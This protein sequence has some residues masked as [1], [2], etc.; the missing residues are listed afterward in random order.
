[1]LKDLIIK[2][3]SVRGYDPSVKVSRGELLEMVDCARLSASSVNLQPLKYFIADGEET[4]RIL[5]EETHLG[6]MLPELHLP[7]PGTEPAAYICICQDT[8]IAESGTAFLKDVGIAAQSITLCA[9]EMGYG[10]CMIG[11]FKP[12]QTRDRLGLSPNAEIRLIVAVGKP[13]EE[14]RIEEIDNGGSTKYY[15]DENGTHHVPKRK[16]EDI[17]LN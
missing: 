7:L 3:R 14:I 2:N 15:R 11:N 4:V 16:L 17:L 6:A 12:E 5:H 10:A 8:D 1:M 13:A 9:A